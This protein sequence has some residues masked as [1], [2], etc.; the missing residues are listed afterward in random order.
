MIQIKG[1]GRVTG[2]EE[3]QREQERKVCADVFGSGF[4]APQDRLRPLH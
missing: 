4:L 1:E 3:S 2:L